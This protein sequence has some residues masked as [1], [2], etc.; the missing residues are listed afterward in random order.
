MIAL[1]QRKAKGLKLNDIVF[2]A[3]NCTD[4]IFA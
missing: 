4:C 3:G 2:V 1:M